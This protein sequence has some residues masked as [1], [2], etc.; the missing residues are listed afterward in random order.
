MG[1]CHNFKEEVKSITQDINVYISL[2]NL[3]QDRAGF[4]GG[5]FDMENTE[6]EK[7]VAIN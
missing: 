6:V 2:I 3:N 5:G 1:K 7:V 4:M